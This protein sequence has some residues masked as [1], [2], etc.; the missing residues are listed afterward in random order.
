MTQEGR[1]ISSAT[2]IIADAILNESGFSHEEQALPAAVQAGTPMTG[3]EMA[4]ML[5]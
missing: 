1:H 4:K 2:V 3:E 5:G